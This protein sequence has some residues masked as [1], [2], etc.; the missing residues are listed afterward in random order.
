MFYMLCLSPVDNDSLRRLKEYENN[1]TNMQSTY[2]NAYSRHNYG[3]LRI[4]ENY[5]HPRAEKLS[6]IFSQKSRM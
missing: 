2:T 1:L 4:A 6:R 3:T 5:K